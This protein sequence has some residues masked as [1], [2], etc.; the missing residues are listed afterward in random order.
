MLSFCCISQE[1]GVM[2]T[3]DGGS[4]ANTL[5]IYRCR[6]LSFLETEKSAVPLKALA[7]SRIQR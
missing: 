4:G 6:E 3:E 7:A 2:H 1:N 5:Y